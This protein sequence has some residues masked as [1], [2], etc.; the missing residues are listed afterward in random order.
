MHQSCVQRCYSKRYW[1]ALTSQHIVAFAL[2]DEVATRQS[3]VAPISAIC[4][5]ALPRA[6]THRGKSLTLLRPQLARYTPY[7][8][9]FSISVQI[10]FSFG[11]S[12]VRKHQDQVRVALVGAQS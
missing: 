5:S 10:F 6:P 2:V 12:K 11:R 3:D 9:R 4:T 8:A 7:S 1:A